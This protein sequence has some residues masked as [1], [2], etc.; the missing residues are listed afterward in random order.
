M[1][2]I[3]SFG[4]LAICCIGL[5]QPHASAWTNQKFGFN[6]TWQHQSGGNSIC[7][8]WQN[9]QPPAPPGFGAAPS[10][11]H[12]A[13]TAPAPHHAHA[14]FDSYEGGAPAFAMPISSAPFQFAAF[15]LPKLEYPN[16]YSNR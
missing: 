10:Y 16:P 7:H 4:L 13:P 3:L 14:S 12:Y 8:V 1:K 11:Y 5:A 2:K 6:L 15:A 9:G